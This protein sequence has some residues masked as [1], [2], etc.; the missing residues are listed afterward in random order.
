MSGW[1]FEASFR[2]SVRVLAGESYL[3]CVT[4]GIGRPERDTYFEWLFGRPTGS[5]PV[6]RR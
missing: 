3:G 1:K 4:F 6:T 5:W 2:V